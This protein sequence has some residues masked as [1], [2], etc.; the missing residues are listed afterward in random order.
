MQE[1]SRT[2]LHTCQGHSPLPEN[3]MEAPPPQSL[4]LPM[5]NFS[6]S[7]LHNHGVLVYSSILDVF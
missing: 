6:V 7:Q 3:C 5:K 1:G 2:V 4:A